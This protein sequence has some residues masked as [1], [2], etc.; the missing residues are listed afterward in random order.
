VLRAVYAFDP[1]CGWCYGFGPA[2]E[3]ARAELDGEVRFELA[4]GGLV[5]G[6]RVRAVR[7]D[8]AYLR[9]GTERVAAVT[10]VRT[11]PGFAALV[12]RGTWVSDSEPVC[13]AL[14]VARETAGDGPALD[15]GAAL[16][17]ALYR[18]GEEPGDPAVIE[19][20]AGAAGLDGAALVTRWSGAEARRGTAAWFARTRAAGVTTY[21]SLLV[22]GPAGRL[23]P[24]L[25]GPAPAEQV[26]ALLRGARPAAGP[27]TGPRPSAPAAGGAG[28]SG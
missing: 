19:R 23:R 28:W 14:W 25:S 15:L 4:C 21:P 12:D 26:V 2:F 7:H 1:L 9:A 20:L 13:R 6:E 11:G 27:P 18:D 17:R 16:C 3:R 10:G 8:A 24:L 5:V 22:P